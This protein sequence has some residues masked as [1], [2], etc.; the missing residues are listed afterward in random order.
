M[1]KKFTNTEDIDKEIKEAEKR[2]KHLQEVKKK[3]EKEKE[4]PE[5]YSI[6][7]KHFVEDT[8]NNNNNTNANIDINH[9]TRRKST[10]TSKVF[11]DV[12]DQALIT[13]GD[14]TF[15]DLKQQELAKEF[16]QKYV[17]NDNLYVFKNIYEQE[18]KET[19]ILLNLPQDKEAFKNFIQNT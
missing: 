8:N 13:H 3:R 16:L 9:K 11:D 19:F 6:Y 18:G 5:K 2:L 4:T 15:L 12:E 10:Q 17:S 7:P 1:S 14:K